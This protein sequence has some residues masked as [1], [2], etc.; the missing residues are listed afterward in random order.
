MKP[1]R[2]SERCSKLPKRESLAETSK[3]RATIKAKIKEESRNVVEKASIKS[4]HLLKQARRKISRK[5][6]LES[7]KFVSRLRDQSRHSINTLTDEVQQELEATV[8]IV[9][10]EALKCSENNAAKAIS[11]ARLEADIILQKAISRLK[12]RLTA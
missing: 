12:N 9:V 6:E 10:D 8:K 5:R 1:S 3:L 7:V 11:D 4:E 2:L